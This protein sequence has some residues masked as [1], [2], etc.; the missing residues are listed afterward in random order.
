MYQK[1]KKENKRLIYLHKYKCKNKFYSR[2]TPS[3]RYIFFVRETIRFTVH[4]FLVVRLVAIKN[5]QDAS[6]E[7]VSCV[8]FTKYFLLHCLTAY[9]SKESKL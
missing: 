3:G 8:N 2:Y 9:V 7:H 4:T 1:K 5:M 6:Q